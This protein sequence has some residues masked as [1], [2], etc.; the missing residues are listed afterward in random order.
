MQ[1]P[2]SIHFAYRIKP[3]ARVQ[4]NAR[5]LVK[6]WCPSFR[7]DWRIASEFTLAPDLQTRCQVFVD[8]HSR[9]SC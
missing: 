6:P 8:E 5:V 3:H 1:K 4:P 2:C 9:A 7:K